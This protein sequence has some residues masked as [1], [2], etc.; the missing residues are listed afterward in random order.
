MD[1]KSLK[2]IREEHQ[3][4]KLEFSKMLNNPYTTYTRYEENLNAAPF[5]IVAEICQKL[6]KKIWEIKC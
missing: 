6:G 3:K 4:S 1:K 5:G 2:E